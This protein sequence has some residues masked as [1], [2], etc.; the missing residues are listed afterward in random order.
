MHDI[1][2]THRLRFINHS[3]LIK[4]IW[5]DDSGGQAAHE[6]TASISSTR[7]APS[8]VEERPG[9]VD[10][11]YQPLLRSGCRY[12]SAVSNASSR[13]DYEIP[14]EDVGPKQ[15]TYLQLVP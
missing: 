4:F 9:S 13:V 10:E 2:L 12:N 7:T 8:S 14:Y 6:T 1:F 5:F 3:K 15:A 11:R